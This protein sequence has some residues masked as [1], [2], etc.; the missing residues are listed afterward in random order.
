METELCFLLKAEI[1]VFPL[2][3]GSSFPVYIII[4]LK[5]VGNNFLQQELYKF[6]KKKNAN[7]E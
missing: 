3:D 1:Y 5:I 4:Y 2:I 6:K 7:D